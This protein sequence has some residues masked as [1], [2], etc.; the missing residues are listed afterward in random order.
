M[1][2]TYLRPCPTNDAWGSAFSSFTCDS[3]ISISVLHRHASILHAMHAPVG[4]MVWAGAEMN[5]QHRFFPAS[6]KN[7]VESLFFFSLVSLKTL[8]KTL[9]TERKR[10]C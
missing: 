9:D 4:S 3:P 8:P 1:I 5:G 7:N 2:S 6:F 10:T